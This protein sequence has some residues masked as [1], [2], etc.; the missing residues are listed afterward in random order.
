M[1]VFLKMTAYCDFWRT[2]KNVPLLTNQRLHLSFE[3]SQNLEITMYGGTTVS[4][5]E[6]E[7]RK[8]DKSKNND[9]PKNRKL[10]QR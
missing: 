5:N 8:E 4:K 1:L 6:D 7:P 3:K 2:R 10:I 9:V